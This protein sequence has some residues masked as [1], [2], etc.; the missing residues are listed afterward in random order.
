MDMVLFDTIPDPVDR[1]AS[2]P[3]AR[4][5]RLSELTLDGLGTP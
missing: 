1:F 3:P 5:L 2:P 4:S